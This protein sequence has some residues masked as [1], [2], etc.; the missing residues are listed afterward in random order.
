MVINGNQDGGDDF[1]CVMTDA[2]DTSKVYINTFTINSSGVKTYS[3]NMLVNTPIEIRV[4][5]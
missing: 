1:R 3:S 5:N 4:Y 2:N